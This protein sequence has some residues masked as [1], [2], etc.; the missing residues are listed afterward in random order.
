[1]LQ[2]AGEAARTVPGEA[3]RQ[4]PWL[5]AVNQYLAKLTFGFFRKWIL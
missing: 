2:T 4:L 3:E 1:M 5:K